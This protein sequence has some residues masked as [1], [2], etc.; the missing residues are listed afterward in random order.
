MWGD[1]MIVFTDRSRIQTGMTCLRKRF[2]NYNYGGRGIERRGFSTPAQTGI[3]VHAGLDAVILGQAVDEA[4]E[5]TLAAYRQVVLMEGADLTQLEPEQAEVE[6]VL[7]EEQYDLTEGIVRGWAAVAWPRMQAEYETLAVEREELAHFVVG[8][9]EVRLGVRTDWIVRRR[10]D[11]G[12]FI[13]NFKTVA[14]A[15]KSWREQWRYDMVSLSE[16]LA[17]EERLSVET[18]EPVKLG[19]VVIQ[20]LL[21]GRRAE[22]PQGSG[23][24]E[25]NS[26]LIRCWYCK[27][28]PPM[29]EDEFYPLSRYDYTC[30]VPHVMRNGKKCGG[31]KNH[32][33]SGVRKGLVR[34]VYPGG[35]AGWIA[36]LAANDSEVLESQIVTLDPILRSDWEIE[37]WKRQTLTREVEIAQAAARI[38]AMDECMEREIACDAA[39]PMSSGDACVNS[40]GRPCTF[41]ECCFSSVGSDPL[42]TGLFRIREPNH[43]TELDVLVPTTSK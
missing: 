22:Y 25:H 18:G 41:L 28:E 30:D 26:P 5:Q 15:G 27:G 38:N 35:V 2:L 33:L 23:R 8:T 4:V 29:T 42:S 21:K 6:R 16:C 1:F 11:G 17:V 36:W 3:Q 31:G 12:R 32:R 7:L 19:G 13:I 10:T 39:F 20:G 37:R 24:Y 40:Y 43:A 34:E 14:D 9:D